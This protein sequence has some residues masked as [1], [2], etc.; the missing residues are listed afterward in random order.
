MTSGRVGIL[1][2]EMSVKL[3]RLAV[4]VIGSS[5]IA[6]AIGCGIPIPTAGPP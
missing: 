2:P 5:G 6:Q 4:S 3:A 1:I